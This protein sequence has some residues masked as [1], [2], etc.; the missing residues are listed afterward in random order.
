MASPQAD[1][2]GV[3]RLTWLA[4]VVAVAVAIW[5]VRRA[6]THEPPPEVRVDLLHVV[7]L[8]PQLLVTANVEAVGLPAAKALFGEGA[9]SL[10]GLRELCGFEPLLALRRVLF[11]TP[12]RAAQAQGASDFAFVAD[13]SLEPEP[14]LRCAEAVVKKRGGVP[15]RSKLGA[16]TS[17][18]DQTKPL[19]E[20]AI[21][22]DGLFV[23][24][25]G[26]YFRDVIDAAS[27][28]ARGGEAARLRSQIHDGIRRRLAPSQLVVTLLPDSGFTL[29]GV[30]AL[31]F[32][33]ELERDLRLR[34]F[35]ACPTPEACAQVQHVLE[36]ASAEAAREPQLSGLSSLKISPRGAQLDVAGRLPRQ[37]LGRFLA[38]VFS[39]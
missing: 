12:F 5:L 39:L 30:N 11:A 28:M 17:V 16:F 31:G 2:E 15:V 35:V 27:G 23:L 33:L 34:G 38:Q 21:R 10:L 9:S 1:S 13:T 29:P 3:R 22:S 8:G 20:V 26:Q 18:R 36:R 7:P 37:Q 14:A 24:S 25:G 19:G 4:L 32:S 6:K